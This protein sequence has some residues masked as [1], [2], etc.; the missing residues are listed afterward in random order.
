MLF[1]LFYPVFAVFKLPDELVLSIL[2]YLAPNIQP[3]SQW[4]R[5]RIHDESRTDNYRLLRVRFLRPLSMTCRAMRLRLVP[6]IWEDIQL[7]QTHRWD[8][9]ESVARKL[10]T[11]TNPL[12]AD[13]FPATSV[14]C[15]YPLL[16]FAADADSRPLKVHDSG[17]RVD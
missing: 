16:L 12:Y 5:F 7:L 14:R 4:V 15:F 3:T 9:R 11:I 17:S 6:W 2:S 10:N 13:T 8:G 1:N